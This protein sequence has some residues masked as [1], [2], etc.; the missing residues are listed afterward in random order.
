MSGDLFDPMDDRGTRRWKC[1]EFLLGLEY[2]PDDPLPTAEEIAEMIRSDYA[3]E[4][5][6]DTTRIDMLFVSLSWVMDDL[7]ELFER[8]EDLPTAFM[9]ARTAHMLRT[10]SP[11]RGDPPE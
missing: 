8:E 9:Y 4:M 3:V 6:D 7:A 11:L 2:N 5:K 10:Q 1:A